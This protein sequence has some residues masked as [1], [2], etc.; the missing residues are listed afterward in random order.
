MDPS[1]AD[2]FDLS[3][4]VALLTGAAR[5]I[6]C[7]IAEALAAVGAAVAVAAMDRDGANQGTPFIRRRDAS[8]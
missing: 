4:K 2:L 3:S 1:V 6:G 5:G 8:E 7:G